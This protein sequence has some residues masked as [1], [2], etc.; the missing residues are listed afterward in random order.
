MTRLITVVKGLGSALL[1]AAFIVG[2]PAVMVRIGAF[3]STVPDLPAMWQAAIRPDTGNRAVFAVLA[4]LVWVAWASFTLSVLR[5][6]GT[7]IRTRG[8]RSARPVRGLTWSARPAEILV[9][10]IVAVFVAA[11]LGPAE[12]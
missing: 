8:E 7:A 10:A 11:P 6:I 4:V 9:A 3:P 1:L 12:K 5:E 2:V